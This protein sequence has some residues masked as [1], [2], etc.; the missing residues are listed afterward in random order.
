MRGREREELSG[1]GREGEV[2]VKEVRL[3]VKAIVEIGFEGERWRK[4]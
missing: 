4:A 1:S 2:C 3:A